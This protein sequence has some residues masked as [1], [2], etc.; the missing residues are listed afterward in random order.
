MGGEK[1]GW[2]Q[3]NRMG[4]MNLNKRWE[5]TLPPGGYEWTV[6]AVDAARF[7]GNFAPKQIIN[8]STGVAVQNSFNPNISNSNGIL[9]IKNCPVNEYF[10]LN[11]YAP[12]GMKVNS[13]AFREAYAL[14]LK[15]GVYIIEIIGNNNFFTGK[16]LIL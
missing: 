4:N 8:I 3:V 12:D 2:R 11:I 9:Y 10:T 6:Q 13:G 14:S 16:V 7:G 1:D 5:L 15:S